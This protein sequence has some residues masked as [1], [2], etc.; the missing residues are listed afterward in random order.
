MSSSFKVFL[1]NI[2]LQI[3]ISFNTFSINPSQTLDKYS[4][5]NQKNLKYSKLKSINV[6][7]STSAATL[8]KTGLN[9]YFNSDYKNALISFEK[10]L[11]IFKFLNDSTGIS[12]CY[13]NIAAVYKNL[14]L[15]EKAEKLYFEALKI[16][17]TLDD[18]FGMAV[19]FNNIGEIYHIKGS[20]IKAIY[21]YLNS[22]RLEKELDNLNGI[23]DCCLNMGA[24]FEENNMFDYALSYYNKA[25]NYYIQNNDYYRLAQCYNN[26]G[27]LCTKTNSF[28]K[29]KDYFEK[30]IKIKLENNFLD[31]LVTS[32][33]NF[34]CLNIL[35]NDTSNALN[36]FNKA[37]DISNDSMLDF[38]NNS[39]LEREISTDDYFFSWVSDNLDT[40]NY[41]LIA[42]NLH[43][44]AI[45]HYNLGDYHKAIENFINS[46]ELCEDKSMRHLM[47]NNYFYLYKSFNNLNDYKNALFYADRYIVL[48]DSNYK[49]LIN[50]F[51]NIVIEDDNPL[52]FNKEK[53]ESIILKTID[54]Q[55]FYKNIWFYSTII[56]L[57]LF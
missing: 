53:E 15:L 11:E 4:D 40:E 45:I 17:K 3:L 55:K 46:L 39:L 38:K 42:E 56:L 23:A 34:G 5:K 49:S 14:N 54:E 28:Y 36:C 20:Y 16:D 18:K 26:L 50:D 43:Y 51:V 10:S 19:I 2:I 7:D 32:L 6:N 35:M 8:K 21:F 37:L 27:V 25:L 33:L 31:P 22:L 47:K 9:Y 12:A 41:G 1:T 48:S 30:S 13:C 24:V 29:A 44:K 57:L 52:L